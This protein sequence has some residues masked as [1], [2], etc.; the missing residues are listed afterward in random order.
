MSGRRR[1]DEPIPR[2]FFNISSVDGWWDSDDLFDA[3]HPQTLLASGMNG[4]DLPVEHGAP[5]RL[6]IERQ[7]G[8]KSLKY[9]TGLAQP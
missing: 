7:F 3:L 8:N 5:M 1:E 6:C 4:R 2:R 9:L